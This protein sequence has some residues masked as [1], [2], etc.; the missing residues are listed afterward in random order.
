[1]TLPAQIAVIVGTRPEAIKMAPVVL[2]L[3]GS[4]KTEPILIATGQHGALFDEALE[5]FGLTP[6]I[7]L[8][9]SFGGLD[10][11]VMVDAIKALLIPVLEQIQPALALV[12]GD[13]TSALAAA[14]AAVACSIPIGH[15]EAG[16][17]SHDLQRPWPEEGNRIAIDRIA[18]LLFAPTSGNVANLAADPSVR[19]QVH[20][21]GNSG[22]DA[23]LHIYAP[24]AICDARRSILATLHR[25][26]TIG[27]PLRRICGVLRNLA[28]REDVQITLPLHPN[29]AVRS[30]ISDALGDH[31]AIAL[32]EPFA[33]PEMVARMAAADLIL[34]DSGGI[35]EEAPAL[36]VPLLILR[37][38]TERPEAMECGGA[39]LAGTD[40][41]VIEAHATRLLDD[42]AART[43]MAVPRFPF[44]R[45]DASEKIVAVIE[46]YLRSQN[47][48]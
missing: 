34:S 26:E 21:T 44:G 1:L 15:V 10:P 24:P 48:T 25:R 43:A 33:Y 18:T 4:P 17:R 41:D 16:L 35:Q 32:L 45:G 31:D 14:Q 36:G 40:P 6:D 27:E 11:E 29:P 28:D 3:R 23:L 2:A 7:R 5:P 8:N 30:I 38:V 46:N 13:T 22:I 9:A 42:V 12:Q 39:I 20:L 19:G 37:D 47:V